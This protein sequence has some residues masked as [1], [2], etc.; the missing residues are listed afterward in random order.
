MFDNVPDWAMGLN[1]AITVCDA[2]GIVLY[3]NEK[4][5]RTFA[6]SGGADLIGK[7]LFPCHSERSQAMIKQFIAEGKSNS[8]TILK[9]GV[10]KLI[11]QTPWY[12][13]GKVAG[14]VEISIEI[15]EEMPHY[16]R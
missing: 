3:M 7:S 1:C 11:Y 2:Q 9:N 10:K 6:K 15:P 5:Q 12:Q 16:V 4:S 13:E 14:M 8:Y